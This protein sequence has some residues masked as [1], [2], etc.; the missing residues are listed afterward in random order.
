MELLELHFFV[1]PKGGVLRV[2]TDPVVG[3]Q[4]HIAAFDPKQSIPAFTE[5]RG[6]TTES[7]GNISPILKVFL[8]DLLGIR[9]LLSTSDHHHLHRS[10][11]KLT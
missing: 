4:D 1:V 11:T 2:L 10:R 8:I 9:E 3:R 7:S 5:E 6:S